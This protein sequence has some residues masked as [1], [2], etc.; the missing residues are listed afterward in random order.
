MI[1]RSRSFTCEVFALALAITGCGADP[2]TPVPQDNATPDLDAG[3]DAPDGSGGGGGDE[4]SAPKCTVLQRNPFGNVAESE[5]LLWDGDFEWSSPFSDQYGW[6][7]GPPLS[8]AFD[9][10]EIGSVCRSGI[11]CASLK[12]GKILV[13]IGVASKDASLLASFWMKPA[14]G[15]CS[16]VTAELF[17][18]TSNGD[19]DVAIGATS[20][21]PDASGW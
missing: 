3:T 1:R 7:K 16:G 6:L 14:D 11:K 8:Y 17:G 2:L 5:N 20:E 13:A 12:K 19:E 10:V 4:P 15:S 21:A 18:L 9:G